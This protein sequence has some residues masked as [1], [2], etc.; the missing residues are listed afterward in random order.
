MVAW[1]GVN[2]IS[3]Q[4]FTPV[5]EAALSADGFQEDGPDQTIMVGFGHNA[6]MSVADNDAS[7]CRVNLTATFLLHTYFL[8]RPC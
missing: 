1:P 5:I 4:D 7:L 6:V 8:F 2:H 3:N